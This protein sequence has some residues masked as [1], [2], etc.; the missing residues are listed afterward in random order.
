MMCPYHTTTSA[1]PL[2]SSVPAAIAYAAP[3]VAR[4][5]IGVLRSGSLSVIVTGKF[6]WQIIS[7]TVSDV[8]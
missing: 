6:A 3:H 7:D 5:N 2:V 4:D 1:W 8:S